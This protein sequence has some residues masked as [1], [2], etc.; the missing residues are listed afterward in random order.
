MGAAAPFVRDPA[1]WPEAI[2]SDL[3]QCLCNTVSLDWG[4][5][6]HEHT[7]LLFSHVLALGAK[8]RPRQHRRCRAFMS[9]SS[10]GHLRC[11]GRPSGIWMVCRRLT[12]QAAHGTRG[13]SAE[14]WD[15]P[16]AGGLLDFACS[17][18][19]ECQ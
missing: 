7:E 9:D 10:M 3:G 12:A 13:L 11:V 4:I 19:A 5:N 15:L 17:A 2:V 6:V 16:T 14:G 18:F 1:E 8:L